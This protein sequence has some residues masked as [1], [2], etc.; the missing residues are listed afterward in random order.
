MLIPICWLG[1]LPPV[2]RWLPEDPV[3]TGR[4]I[5]REI[6][7]AAMVL[8]NQWFAPMTMYI[9]AEGM[10]LGELF[11]DGVVSE[12]GDLKLP[13]RVVV[14]ANHQTYPDFLYIW[15]FAYLAKLHGA[16]LI[17]LKS[18]FEH[19]LLIGSG[20]KFFDFVFL[21]RQWGADRANI[22]ARLERA[23]GGWERDNPLAL[24]IFPE[25]TVLSEGT[26]SKMYAF[27][28]KTDQFKLPKHCLLPRVTG[29]YHILDK[30]Q[31]GNVDYLYDLT[32]A[33]SGLG[34]DEIAEDVYKLVDSFWY[35]ENAER[36]HIRVRRWHISTEV[37]V[38]EGVEAFGAWLN[39]RWLE[40]DQMLE[41]FYATGSLALGAT[42]AEREDETVVQPMCVRSRTHDLAPVALLFGIYWMAW[43]LV[44][45]VFSYL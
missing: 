25:G 39:E 8:I 5:G 11:E 37:P 13:S 18:G 21:R 10:S 26:R 22:T 14:M 43:R 41:R 38:Q 15:V 32:M 9:T 42:E 2:R 3:R 45:T 36:L 27:A 17:L 6:F 4:R 24:L 19:L 12:W 16:M 29:L 7:G 31:D 30:L 44:C 34:A 40:K 28:K 1:S 35:G 33:F 23:K 20:M